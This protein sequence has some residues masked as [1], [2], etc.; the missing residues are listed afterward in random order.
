VVAV[1]VFWV[2][3]IRAVLCW[4]GAARRVLHGRRYG[5]S[6]IKSPPQSDEQRHK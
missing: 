2:G 1:G 6:A 4:D 3:V 5:P